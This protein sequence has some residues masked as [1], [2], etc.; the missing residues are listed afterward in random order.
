MKK[1][2]PILIGFF[3]TVCVAIFAFYAREIAHDTNPTYLVSESVRKQ[4]AIDI[5]AKRTHAEKMRYIDLA[6]E[7]RKS[8][9]EHIAD[10]KNIPQDILFW[11]AVRWAILSSSV[12]AFV[13]L[14]IMA[15]LTGKQLATAN[16]DALVLGIMAV[17]PKSKEHWRLASA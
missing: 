12:A 5:E 10:I 3:L 9:D 6:W 7:Y 17:F 4:N 8:A 11:N 15:G 14:V 2:I 1:Q 13:I 16:P